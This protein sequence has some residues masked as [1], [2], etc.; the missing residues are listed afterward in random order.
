[1]AVTSGPKNEL[2]LRVSYRRG[3]KGLEKILALRTA[4]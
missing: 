2:R 3:G 4:Q 1:M